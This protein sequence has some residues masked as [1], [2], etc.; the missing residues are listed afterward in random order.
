MKRWKS[1]VI[2]NKNMS[3]KEISKILTLRKKFPNK[4]DV[5]IEKE[6]GFYIAEILGPKAFLGAFTQASN[7]SELIAMVNDCV[8][9]ILEIPEKYS[10]EMPQYMPSISLAQELNEFPKQTF[11]ESVQFS[12]I[13]SRAVCV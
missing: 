2:N 13:D 3:K 5:L 10:S 8:Q 6:N 12:I 4:I 1:F 7:F 11:K 9:T